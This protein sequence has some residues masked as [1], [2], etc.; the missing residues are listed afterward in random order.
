MS[1]N[2]AGSKGDVT[3]NKK[4]GSYDETDSVPA[5]EETKVLITP[6]CSFPDHSRADFLIAY[7]TPEGN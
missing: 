6:I 7:A 3:E 1:T 2:T 4:K 5:P